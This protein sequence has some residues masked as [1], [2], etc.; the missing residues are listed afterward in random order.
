MEV[1]TAVFSPEKEPY[2]GQHECDPNEAEECEDRF[3]GYLLRRCDA[4]AG[5]SEC[6]SWKDVLYTRGESC[7]SGGEVMEGGETW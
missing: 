2:S 5:V 7:G 1:E 3:V 4:G 6:S